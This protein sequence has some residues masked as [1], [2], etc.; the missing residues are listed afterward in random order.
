M[1]AS[2]AAA[3]SIATFAQPATRSPAGVSREPRGDRSISVMPSW[4]SSRR[5]WVLAAG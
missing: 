4:R 2:R 5:S 3:A 1:P